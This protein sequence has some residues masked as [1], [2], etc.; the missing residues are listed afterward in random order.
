VGT[1]RYFKQIV[2]NTKHRCDSSLEGTLPQKSDMKKT[3]QLESRIHANSKMTISIFLCSVFVEWG[4]DCCWKRFTSDP[5]LFHMGHP[6]HWCCCFLKVKTDTMILWFDLKCLKSLRWA[7]S[8][9][10]FFISWANKFFGLSF[11]SAHC[12][13]MFD[14]INT[15]MFMR[16]IAP[17]YMPRH[18]P[19]MSGWKTT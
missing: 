11:R 10:M 7:K 9:I 15:L 8:D 6:N 3:D 4:V 2:E 1:K 16:G 5:V 13:W 12:V 18:Q 14:W 19:K 17:W